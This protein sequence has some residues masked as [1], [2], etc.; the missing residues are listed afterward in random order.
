MIAK[1]EKDD[2]QKC[3]IVNLLSSHVLDPMF[4]SCNI[5]EN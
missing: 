2:K 1:Y 3:Y 5:L 4:W